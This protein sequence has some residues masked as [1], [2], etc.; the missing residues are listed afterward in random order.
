M[1]R[2]VC[3]RRAEHVTERGSAGQ[4]DFGGNAMD[5][6]YAFSERMESLGAYGVPNNN[7]VCATGPMGRA[8][9]VAFVS[10]I[11]A[12]LCLLVACAPQQ[13]EP[14][15]D[16]SVTEASGAG[17]SLVQSDAEIIDAHIVCLGETGDAQKSD[18]Q[19]YDVLSHCL[20]AYLMITF[21]P[22]TM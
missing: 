19:E 3:I 21:L 11:A 16:A 1:Q 4:A 12:A 15:S 13:K 10:L 5:A 20:D 18:D 2:H 7:A 22:L 8:V 17:D 9:L 6:E 14:G